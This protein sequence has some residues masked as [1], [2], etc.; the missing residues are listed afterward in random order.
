MNHSLDSTHTSS[1]R[2]QG[3]RSNMGETGFIHIYGMHSQTYPSALLT[4]LAVSK[5][6]MMVAQGI[7]W[8]Q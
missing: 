8:L 4:C 5:K 7:L 1:M 6:T 3:N 2:K